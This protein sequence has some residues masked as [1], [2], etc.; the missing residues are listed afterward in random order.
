MVSSPLDCSKLFTVQPWHTYSFRHQLNFSG[1][2]SVMQVPLLRE[3]YSLNFEPW[4][5]RLRVLHSTTE[6]PCST[7][8]D[9][10]KVQTLCKKGTAS[11]VVAN[12]R[13]LLY[14]PWKSRR[15]CSMFVQQ[16]VARRMVGLMTNIRSCFSSSAP[17][18]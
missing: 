14:S 18:A 9:A 2:V 5:S 4:L 15:V 13:I 8:V 11:H 6:L 1:K 12:C 17:R 7:S 3:D 10:V 16:S